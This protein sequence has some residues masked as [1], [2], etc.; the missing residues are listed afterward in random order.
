MPFFMNRRFSSSLAAYGA[1]SNLVV[2]L[3]TTANAPLPIVPTLLYLF[4]PFH[5]LIRLGTSDFPEILGVSVRGPA[6]M[7]GCTEVSYYL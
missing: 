5:S 4:P 6:K 3:Y 1:P 7:S 2:T